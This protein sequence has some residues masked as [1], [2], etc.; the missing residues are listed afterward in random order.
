MTVSI[1]T[2]YNLIEINSIPIEQNIQH[3]VA[4]TNSLDK[5]REN[6]GHLKFPKS[7]SKE[8]IEK[9]TSTKPKP[10]DFSNFGISNARRRA[11]VYERD[12]VT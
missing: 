4:P 5:F 6:I 3:N 10:N 12:V 1:L 2:T 9:H 8:I 7:F 11:H